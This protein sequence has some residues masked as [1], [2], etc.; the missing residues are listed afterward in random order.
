MLSIQKSIKRDDAC[1]VNILPCRVH[2]N[3]PAKVT[4]RYWDP[5]AEKGTKSKLPLGSLLTCIDGSKV[6]YFRGRKL[7]GTSVRIPEGYKGMYP[8][9]H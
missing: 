1:T 6:A 9:Y 7:K 8:I 5:V 2:H 3:G 4:K